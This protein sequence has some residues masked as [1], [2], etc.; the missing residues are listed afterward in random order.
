MRAP[1]KRASTAFWRMYRSAL[2]LWSDRKFKSWLTLV[3]NI[4]RLVFML[5]RGTHAPTDT[6]T[7]VAQSPLLTVEACG[8]GV[9]HL[10]FGALSLRLTGEALESV[11][12]TIA[13][14]LQFVGT[15]DSITDR[16]TTMFSKAGPVRGKA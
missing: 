15:E 11:Q 14:A 10:H 7:V 13:E 1:W 9:M 8:C 2:A 3:F 12:R 16:V 6:R 5:R 4:D